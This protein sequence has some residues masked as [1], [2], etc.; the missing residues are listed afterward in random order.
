MASVGDSGLTCRLGT[1][2]NPETGPFFWGAFSVVVKGLKSPVL[3]VGL[4]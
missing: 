3:F 4:L 2:W 1:S